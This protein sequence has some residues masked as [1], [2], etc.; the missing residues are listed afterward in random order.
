MIP[1]CAF[2]FSGGGVDSLCS[3]HTHSDRRPATRRAPIK[4]RCLRIWCVALRQGVDDCVPDAAVV[5]GVVAVEQDVAERDD[6]C[7]VGNLLK[8]FGIASAETV[9]GFAD[10]FE[11]ALRARAKYGFL[12]ARV[13]TRSTSRP[14]SDFSAAR[15]S[16][17]WRKGPPA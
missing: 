17:Y 16:K 15:K 7:V 3:T 2:L 9:Q 10:D 5:N 13:S 12:M 14:K 4:R 8:R 1:S 6:S 11:V